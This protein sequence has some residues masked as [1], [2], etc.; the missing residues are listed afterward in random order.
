VCL[1]AM[2]TKFVDT[3][4]QTDIKLRVLDFGFAF[5]NIFFVGGMA[6]KLL[7]K[8]A[9]RARLYQSGRKK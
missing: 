2:H 6:N 9:Y 7:K 3:F 8:Q 4:R 1:D 5:F